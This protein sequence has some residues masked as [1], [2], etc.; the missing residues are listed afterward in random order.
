MLIQEP[1]ISPPRTLSVLSFLSLEVLVTSPQ[2]PTAPVSEERRVTMVTPSH[3]LTSDITHGHKDPQATSLL[4]PAVRY[5]T[6]PVAIEPTVEEPLE[7]TNVD[8]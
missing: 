7:V 8:Q 1:Q 5:E 3:N 2:V 4:P 6:D